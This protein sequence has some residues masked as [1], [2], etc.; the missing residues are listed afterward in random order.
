[1]SS[2]DAVDT[3]VHMETHFCQVQHTDYNSCMKLSHYCVTSQ[4]FVI[5]CWKAQAIQLSCSPVLHS[6]DLDQDKQFTEDE[7]MK[8]RF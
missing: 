3:Q 1:M 4:Y 6:Q 7:R 2:L 8:P 5:F